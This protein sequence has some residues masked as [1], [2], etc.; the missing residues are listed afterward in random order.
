M[1]KTFNMHWE[2]LLISHCERRIF[3]IEDS[4]E[5]IYLTM[6]EFIVPLYVSLFEVNVH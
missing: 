2:F 3:D 1:M 4:I 6:N 5:C